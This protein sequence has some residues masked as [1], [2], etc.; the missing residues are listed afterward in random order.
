MACVKIFICG[1]AGVGKTCLINQIIYS[2]FITEHIPTFIVYNEH[3]KMKIE[4]KELKLQISELISQPKYYAV[5]KI[6]IKRANIIFLMYDSTNLYSFDKLRDWYNLSRE[7]INNCLYVVISTKNDLFENKIVNSNEG[8]NFAISINALFKEISLNDNILVNE[9]F[10]DIINYYIQNFQNEIEKEER[11][12]LVFTRKINNNEE[13]DYIHNDY[14]LRKFVPLYY[15][16][17]FFLNIIL[18]FI[19]GPIIFIFFSHL[20]K[21]IDKFEKNNFS[22][23][24]YLTLFFIGISF[25][26]VIS[27]LSILAFPFLIYLH[28]YMNY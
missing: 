3:K 4:D 5:N 21:M 17:I 12:K 13:D 6:F 22:F 23:F 8:N 14:K 16:D 1:E 11:E 27:F 18:I 19:G 7:Q 20:L 28:Y 24:Y 10:N 26:G 9:V 25:Q 2:Q 15:I